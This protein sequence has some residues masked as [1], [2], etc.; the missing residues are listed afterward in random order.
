MAYINIDST[1]FEDGTDNFRFFRFSYETEK[2]EAGLTK[3]R[4][5]FS[6]RYT[7]SASELSIYCDCKLTASITL[8]T[9]VGTLPSYSQGWK[10]TSFKNGQGYDGGASHAIDKSGEF[11]IKHNLD[12]QAAFKVIID[13]NI[14]YSNGNNNV[15]KTVAL[16]SNIPY[17]SVTTPTVFTAVGHNANNEKVVP[18][19]AI[20]LNWSGAKAG[21]ENPINGYNIYYQIT[22]TGAAPSG[23]ET[24]TGTLS[25]LITVDAK[26]SSYVFTAPK[27]DD[28]RGYKIAFAIR[29]IGKQSGYSSDLKNSSKITINKK[30][31]APAI[32]FNKTKLPNRGGSFEITFSS[33]YQVYYNNTGDADG[34]KKLGGSP[35]SLSAPSDGSSTSLNYYFW[36][37]DGLEYSATSTQK[38]IKFNQLPTK[39]TATFKDDPTYESVAFTNPATQNAKYYISRN[40][41]LSITDADSSNFTNTFY[42][43]YA[44]YG[45]TSYIKKKIIS[46]TYATLS[47]KDIRKY[48][49]IPSAE[50]DI[51]YYFSVDVNDGYD[52]VSANLNDGD[53]YYLPKRVTYT[54]PH[55]LIRFNNLKGTQDQLNAN[56]KHFYN[57]LRFYFSKDTGFSSIKIEILD[58][59]NN[60]IKTVNGSVQNAGLDDYYKANYR[61]YY[62][63]NSLDSLTAGQSYK[64]RI[65]LLNGDISYRLYTSSLLMKTPSPRP[66]NSA[67]SATSFSPYGSKGD[68]PWARWTIASY[69]VSTEESLIKDYDLTLNSF[70]FYWTVDGVNSSSKKIVPSFSG[71]DLVFSLGGATMFELLNNM[72]LSNRKTYAATLNLQVKN[73]FEVTAVVSKSCTITYNDQLPTITSYTLQVAKPATT[74]QTWFSYVDMK[75]K[76]LKAGLSLAFSINVKDYYGIEK[77]EVFI[78]KDDGVTWQRYGDTITSFSNNPTS[79]KKISEKQS[80]NTNGSNGKFK[81]EMEELVTTKQLCG[82]KIKVTNKAGNS[83][84]S[85]VNKYVYYAHSYPSFV[86]DKVEYDSTDKL[87]I[88]TDKLVTTGITNEAKKYTTGTVSVK[89]SAKGLSSKTVKYRSAEG[90]FSDTKKSSFEFNLGDVEYCYTQLTATTTQTVELSDTVSVTTTRSKKSPQILVYNVVPTIA[91]RKNSL[92]I[93]TNTVEDGAILSVH[94]YSSKNKLIF[95]S[96]DTTGFIILSESGNELPKLSN[97]VIDGGTW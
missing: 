50:S 95:H 74:G 59:S 48:T 73:S 79:D 53:L 92:G 67:L 86:I 80:I 46:T 1:K 70:S 64:F 26:T 57:G 43:H 47:I 8:G 76:F 23:N 60:L 81:A 72:G 88:L 37:F 58:S 12:G 35:S 25:G 30:P 9:L 29:T 68:S 71:N 18:D 49:G 85:N 10:Y 40:L 32:T 69:G 78:S 21:N 3:V 22:T 61:Y 7:G 33:D 31:P 41:T 51:Q 27:S 62:L 20:T 54:K 28:Y 89:A 82:F 16:P 34:R 55:Q 42:V 38:T 90:F 97:F 36:N 14:Y 52:S 83:I 2:I 6:T 77:V 75:T 5:K 84:E 94:A 91:M 66:Q 24:G 15:T 45:T 11:S 4:W 65:Y 93:N 17:T 44:P 13:G 39:I 56:P 87:I 96:G 19:G 63:K